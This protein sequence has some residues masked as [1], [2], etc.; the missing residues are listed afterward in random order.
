MLSRINTRS[1]VVG[2][3][4]SQAAPAS[5]QAFLYQRPQRPN[6]LDGF[7]REQRVDQFLR[8][9]SPE[10]RGDQV[11]G[12]VDDLASR[13]R[14]AHGP[15]HGLHPVRKLRP[16]IERD[17]DDRHARRQETSQRGSGTYF[18]LLRCRSTVASCMR[19]LSCA[20]WNEA[21]LSI[22]ITATMCWR[23]MSGMSRL[24]TTAPTVGAR[25]MTTL[26]TSSASN[27]RCFGC[28]RWRRAA[29]ESECRRSTS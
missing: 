22:S 27:G 16:V 19:A 25:R 24:S 9:G 8:D 1:P 20:A 10:H 17:L 5:V 12:L 18:T 3:V 13:H 21:V 7:D 23:Q 15:P 4:L 26:F 29:L 2:K 11:P 6:V 28:S 14:V